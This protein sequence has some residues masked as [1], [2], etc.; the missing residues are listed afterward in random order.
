MGL[1]RTWTII[2]GDAG[3]VRVSEWDSMH[4]PHDVK[5]WVDLVLEPSVESSIGSN[6]VAEYGT[7]HGPSQGQWRRAVTEALT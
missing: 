5:Q 4:K 7:Q 3:R 6:I 1:R 2:P